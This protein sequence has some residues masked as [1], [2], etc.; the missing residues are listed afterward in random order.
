MKGTISDTV[1]NW[2]APLSETIKRLAGMPRYEAYLAHLRAH[3]P[4]CAIP[5]EGQY[6]ELYLQGKYNGGGN[7]CC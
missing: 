3:H 5:T 2:L 7:R 6:Y 1:R 4:E